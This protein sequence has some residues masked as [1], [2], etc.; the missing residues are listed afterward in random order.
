MAAAASLGKAMEDLAKLY[1]ER[2]PRHPE[3][4]VAVQT[5]G[6][7]ALARKALELDL[8]ADVI[9][10]AD[11][12]LFP[13]LLY[14]NW[15]NF[16]LR[17][18]SERIVL[19]YT[20]HSP[21]RRRINTKN[22]AQVLSQE[23]VNVGMGNPTQV[24]VGYRALMAL[25]LA[26]LQPGGGGIEKAILE[27]SPEKNWRSDVAELVAPLQ[28]G[29]LDYAFLYG[30]TAKDA[31]L[32]FVELPPEIN[33]SDPARADAYAKVSVTIAGKN[34]GEK[35]EKKGGPIVYG[36]GL[37]AKPRGGADAEEFLALLFSKDGR[38]ILESHGFTLIRDRVHLVR[39]ELPR[40]LETKLGIQ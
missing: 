4:D 20:D 1:E 33:L 2:H 25:R 27:K 36:I 34:P 8:P 14:P 10:L 17:F 32:S 22:W 6:S 29:A 3:V 37:A 40:A 39:G 16:Y 9:A 28:A 38:R 35:I 31:G 12:S 19:A 24:P 18:A 21:G 26:D 13:D 7:T 5:G 11:D 23:K 30:G 15:C